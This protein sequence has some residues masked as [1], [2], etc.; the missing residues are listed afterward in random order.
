[1]PIPGSRR[2]GGTGSCVLLLLPLLAGFNAGPARAASADPLFPGPTFD[3]GSAPSC[4]AIGDFN[5]DG[6]PDLAVADEGYF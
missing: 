6:K 5:G 2:H 4:V 1:M 3:T